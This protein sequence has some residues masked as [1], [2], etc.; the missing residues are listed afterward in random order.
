M[1]RNSNGVYSLPQAAYVPNTVISSASVNANLS[2]IASALTGSLPVNSSTG[3]TGQFLSTSG[4]VGAPGFA[5]ASDTNTGFYLAGTHQIGWAANGAVQATFN[6]NGSVSWLSAA[7]TT[8]GGNGNFTG[9][10]GVTGATTLGSTVT[11][12][13]AATSGTFTGNLTVN[14]KLFLISTDSMALPNG[15]TGQRNGTPGAGDFRYNSTLNAIEYWNGSSWIS[16]SGINTAPTVQ[17]FTSGTAQTYTPPA[18][19][20]RIKVR[21]VG[22]GGGGNNGGNGTNSSFGS[23]TAVHGNGGSGN[24]GGAGG[25]GGTNGTGTLVFRMS[26]GTGGYGG[27]GGSDNFGGNGGVTFFGGA[28]GITNG[29]PL[30]SEEH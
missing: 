4:N 24:V 23:W 14:G 13:F 21:M 11:G 28:P 2:D 22:A 10:L 18:G 26:G 1:P 12:L 9:T 30:R 3:M 5:F 20:V 19:T 15:T 17:T 6:S 27:T 16:I 29:P 8:W 7:T 25:S